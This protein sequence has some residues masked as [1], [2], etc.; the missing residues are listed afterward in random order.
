MKHF[1]RI[2]P[3]N[4]ATKHCASELVNGYFILERQSFRQK[5]TRIIIQRFPS[6]QRIKM[7]AAV[8]AL[9]NDAMGNRVS[10]PFSISKLWSAIPQEE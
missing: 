6:S 7:A 10:G 5:I 3:D 1:S 9:V 4:Q 2:Q 8:K